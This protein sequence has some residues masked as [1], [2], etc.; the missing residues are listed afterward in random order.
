MISEELL[1][2]ISDILLPIVHLYLQ[3]LLFLTTGDGRLLADVER[4]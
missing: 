4:I 1:N 3:Y 2:I